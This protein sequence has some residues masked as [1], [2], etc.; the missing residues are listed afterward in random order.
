MMNIVI[1]FIIFIGLLYGSLKLT[2]VNC[3]SSW[4]NASKNRLKVSQAPYI[5]YLCMYFLL[6]AWTGTSKTGSRSDSTEKTLN[7]EPIDLLIPTKTGIRSYVEARTAESWEATNRKTRTNNEGTYRL[8]YSCLKKWDPISES[9]ILFMKTYEFYFTF[10]QIQI[11][12]IPFLFEIKIEIECWIRYMH[13]FN[14]WIQQTK[15][16]LNITFGWITCI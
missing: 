9:Q 4:N 7:P 3:K 5:R 6:S 14:D 2:T 11:S 10:L 1:L 12:K 16:S 15:G 8:R 13:F